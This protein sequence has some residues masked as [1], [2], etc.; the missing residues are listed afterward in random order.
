MVTSVRTRVRHGCPRRIRLIDGE[1]RNDS[2]MP[3]K[4]LRELEKKILWLASWTIHNANHLREN[5]DGL[6]VGGHQ[7]SSA[8]LATI[9]TALYFDVLKPT[10]RVAV[11]P[12]ASP[13]FHAIQYLLGKQTRERLEAFRGYKGAQSYPS[14]TKDTDDVDFST[15]S[16]GLG[17]AQTLFSSLVQDYVC[18]HGWGLNQPGRAHGRAGRRRRARRRQYLRGAARRLEAGPAQLLVGHRLQ[19]AEPGCRGARRP[20]GALRATVQEF[21]LG[22][23][24]P[25]IRLAA[26]GRVQG[27]GRRQIAP[28]D[29][30]VPEPALLRAGVRRRRRLAQASQ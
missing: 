29:R 25:E 3:T 1:V 30:P 22:R 14:R 4:S 28:V 18:A 26:T 16:V 15:G 23:G 2:T 5:S 17:V 8:S 13:I 12:H 24:D 21:R 11:K 19:P 27:A 7:A 20:V 10:D 9:M 6:K